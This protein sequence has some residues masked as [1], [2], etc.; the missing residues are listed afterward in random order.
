MIEKGYKRQVARDV[1]PKIAELLHLDDQFV[2]RAV[3]V[4]DL[5]EGVT[6]EVTKFCVEKDKV[7]S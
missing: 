6:A 4:I 1:W 7:E 3:I 2:K 5:E